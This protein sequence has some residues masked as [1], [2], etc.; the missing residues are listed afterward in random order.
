VGPDFMKIP[1]SQPDLSAAERRAVLEVLESTFLSFGP[2]LVE[3]ERA[4]AKYVGV[5]HAVAVNSGTSALHLIVR[6]LGISPGHEVIT[7]P[8][9]FIAS[10]NCIMVEGAR[11]IFVD[12]DPDTYNLDVSKIE[13]AVTSKTKAILPVDVFGRCAD[14]K[15]I[16][17][18][19][20]HHNLAVIED[21]CEAIGAESGGKKAGSFGDAG[22]FGFYP[23]KQMTTGE[24]GVIVTDRD[25]L[26]AACRSMRNQGRNDGQGWM[27]HAR[28]GFN[29]RLGD[30]NCALGLAQLSRLEDML[31][32][33]AAVAELYR[34]RLQNIQGVILPP[35]VTEGRLSWFVYV[36]RLGDCYSRMDRDRVLEGLRAAG[37]GCSNYFP[38]IHLQAH[39]VRQWGYRPGDFPVTERVAE[40][41]I[42]LPFFNA[43]TASQVNEVAECLERQIR[44]LRNSS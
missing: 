19:A 36:V 3:F 15:G 1:L 25:D 22:C 5:R 26:A 13:S 30:L 14:W 44:Q 31:S 28:I 11:P 35:P 17:A 29:Y 42:A 40:H 20:R 4:M 34:E 23:N 27:E 6:A 16:Y 33:R 32:R 10:A 12:I 8:F 9:S 38:P 7:T 39:Y 2:K 37:I 21:S 41:T 24:G 18:I 43:L